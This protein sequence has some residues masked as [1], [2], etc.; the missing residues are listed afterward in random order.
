MCWVPESYS[1][2]APGITVYFNRS[3]AG[4]A[5]HAANTT[6]T[7]EWTLNCDDTVFIMG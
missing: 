6:M 1:Y 4:D 3:D 7:P 2:V 5:I